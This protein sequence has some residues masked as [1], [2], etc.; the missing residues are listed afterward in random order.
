MLHVC[1]SVQRAG[2]DGKWWQTVLSGL[3]NVATVRILSRQ[4]SM[5]C[6]QLIRQVPS[7]EQ[8]TSL[9]LK[10]RHSSPPFPCTTRLRQ[11]STYNAFAPF[12]STLR[13]E[14]H[15]NSHAEI[16]AV[17]G[18]RLALVPLPTKFSTVREPA[19][20]FSLFQIMCASLCVSFFRVEIVRR[21][22]YNSFMQ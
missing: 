18:R 17:L 21:S 7:C 14:L 12:A 1:Q 11:G 5:P 3:E 2:R 9:E 8:R 20:Y 15:R 6:R 16:C 10:P 22:N 13:L 4:H 19:P